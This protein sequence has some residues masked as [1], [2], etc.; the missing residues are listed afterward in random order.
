VTADTLLAWMANPPCFDRDVELDL[1]MFDLAGLGLDLTKLAPQLEGLCGLTSSPVE[2]TLK[3]R[4]PV[5]NVHTNIRCDVCNISPI[6]GVRYQ[7]TVCS[8][9][10]LCASCESK[11]ASHPIDHPLVK[12]RQGVK[13]GVEEVVHHGVTCDGC[14]QSP[15][16]GIRF[17]CKVCA[18]FD[19]CTACEA[20]NIHPADHPMFKFKMERV[21]GQ[22]HQGFFPGGGCRRMGLGMGLHRRVAMRGSCGPMVRRIQ[23]ALKVPT[24]GFFGP[25]TETAVQQFQAA[26]DLKVDGIVGPL[27]MA[28]LFF[29]PVSVH[30]SSPTPEKKEEKPTVSSSPSSSLSVEDVLVSMGFEDREVNTRLLK[31]HNGN[32]EAVVQELCS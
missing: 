18:D 6:V 22:G 1:G 10:D 27:T 20:K 16:K 9:F 25:Q 8:D 28:K 26:N 7:C 32:L 11:P 13:R 24:D 17:K 5:S 12:H 30:V 4:D 21:R 19:L 14:Q 31:K 15:I 23:E 2:L 3:K 29:A